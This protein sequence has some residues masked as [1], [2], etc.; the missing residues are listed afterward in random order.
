MQ[1]IDRRSAFAALG[2]AAATGTPT[3]TAARGAAAQ[4]YRPDEGQETA[5]GVRRVLV[6]ERASIAM[7]GREGV[8][9]IRRDNAASLRAHAWMGMREVAGST[10]G[11]AEMAVLAYVG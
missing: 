7:G 2:L 6:S 10:H 3:L 9:L 4:P 8:L 5:P 1:D 11:G